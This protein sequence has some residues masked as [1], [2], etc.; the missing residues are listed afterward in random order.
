MAIYT[1]KGIPI[2]LLLTKLNKP[3]YV[4]VPQ[5]LYLIKDML[6]QKQKIF[7]KKH[8]KKRRNSVLQIIVALYGHKESTRLFHKDFT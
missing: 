7:L 4:R 1:I 8:Y 2:K 6:D 3:V 5:E